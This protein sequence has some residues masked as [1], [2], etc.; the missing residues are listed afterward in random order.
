MMLWHCLY[1]AKPVL[2]VY[3]AAGS[4]RC[5][6]CGCAIFAKECPNA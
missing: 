4:L 1:C 2:A 5:M 3:N 6:E